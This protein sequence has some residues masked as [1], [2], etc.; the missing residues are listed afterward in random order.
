MII[1]DYDAKDGRTLIEWE[2]AQV[3]EYLPILPRTIELMQ[4]LTGQ[5]L[6]ATTQLQQAGASTRLCPDEVRWEMSELMELEI[7]L[8]SLTSY[9][10]DRHAELM[11][12][13]KKDEKI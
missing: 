10:E 6:A 8:G 7:D 1:S 4:R 13:A 2:A 11:N 3:A 5:L 9:L 12:R